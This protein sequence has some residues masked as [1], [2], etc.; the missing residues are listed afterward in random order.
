VR[1]LHLIE[2]GGPGGAERVLLA[3]AGSLGDGY[4]SVVGLARG[5]W[6]AGQ[7]RAAGLDLVDLGGRGDLGTLGAL[8]RLIRR[9]RIRVVHAHEFYMALLA[10]AAGALTGVPAVCTVHGKHYYPDRRRRRLLYRL[11]A[12]RAARV[13]AVSGELRAFFCGVT[14]VARD[15]VQVVYNGIDVAAYAG[16]RGDPSRRVG[17]GIPAD[18]LV[19]GSIGNLY[20]VKGHACLLRAAALLR[21]RGGDPHVVI[22]GRGEQREPLLA[23][24]DTLGLSSRLHLPGF[25]EDAASY[26]GAMDMFALPSQSEGMPLSLLEAMAAGLPVVASAVGGVPE[27]LE[28]G[29]TGLLVSPADPVALAAALHRLAANPALAGELGLA[30]QAEVRRRF[31]VDAM[32][33]AYREIYRDACHRRA[34]AAPSNAVGPLGPERWGVH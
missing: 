24:A 12:R 31:S 15:A 16:V 19:V 13:V 5:G 1:V 30:A 6:L 23:L 3:V 7:V 14:G 28:D 4:R 25:R 2:T 9:R 26:L 10:T 34:P 29:R 18:A 20:A 11:A 33:S 17:L 22:L 27:A 21:D 32:V 8:L